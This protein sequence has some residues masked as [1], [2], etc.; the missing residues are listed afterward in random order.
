MFLSIQLIIF[1]IFETESI[2]LWRSVVTSIG[3]YI[4]GKDRK[5]NH[6]IVRINIGNF[7]H[8]HVQKVNN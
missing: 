1:K 8:L 6:Y 7:G 2:S 5:L 4:S 3:T